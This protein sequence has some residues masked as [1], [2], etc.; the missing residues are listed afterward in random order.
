MELAF[1]YNFEENS[2]IIKSLIKYILTLIWVG[3]L[4]V[5]FE[6]DPKLAIN[7]KN[8]SDITI[9]QHDIIIKF[10]TLLCF[11]YQV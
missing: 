8:D 3:F 4:G 11:F 6:V 2:K 7:W 9:F 5:R 10:F 1:I